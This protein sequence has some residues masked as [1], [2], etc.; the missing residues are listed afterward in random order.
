MNEEKI[1]NSLKQ[2]MN[3]YFSLSEKTWNE[4]KQICTIKKIKKVIM[5]LIYMTM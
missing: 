4:L 3:S 1:F 2:T 5:P